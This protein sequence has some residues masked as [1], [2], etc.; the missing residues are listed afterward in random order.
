MRRKSAPHAA[1]RGSKFVEHHEPSE[2]SENGFG[3]LLLGGMAHGVDE[4][5]D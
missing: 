5:S 4:S 3:E 1:L 2:P